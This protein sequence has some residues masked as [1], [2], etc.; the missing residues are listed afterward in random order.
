MLSFYRL[1]R[2]VKVRRGEFGGFTWRRIGAGNPPTLA[3]IVRR[4][5]DALRRVQDDLAVIDHYL[6]EERDPAK[7]DLL[8]ERRKRRQDAE[9][10]LSDFLGWVARTSSD[11]P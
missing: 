5:R 2:E 3:D 7:R 8:L 11:R 1:D 9:R 10:F 6:A 4:S